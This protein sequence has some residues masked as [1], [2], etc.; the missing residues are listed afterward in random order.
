MDTRH[1]HTCW[2]NTHPHKITMALEEARSVP[3][4]EA[5]ED[6]LDIAGFV[7]VL[8]GAFVVVLVVVLFLASFCFEKESRSV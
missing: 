1:M 7:A 6:S 2:Q 4:E 5:L 3:G 8:C